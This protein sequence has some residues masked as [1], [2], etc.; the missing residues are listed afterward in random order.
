MEAH[1][2]MYDPDYSHRYYLDHKTERL[3]RS[4][5]WR[6]RHPARVDRI[7]RAH[8]L[9]VKTE[10]L[11]HYGPKGKLRCSWSGCKVKDLDMLSLDYVNNDGARDRAR[12]TGRG[13]YMKLR[14][15]DFPGGFQTLCYNHQMKK[16]IARRRR[17]SIS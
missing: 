11:A 13:I 8:L 16:E 15:Q 14:Q 7:R 9:K 5:L 3:Q 10:V 1:S 12:G 2:K 4:S 6:K 17:V